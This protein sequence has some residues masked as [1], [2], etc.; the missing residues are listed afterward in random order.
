MS[1]DTSIGAVLVWFRLDLRIRDNP[2]LYHAAA[3]GLPVIPVF[4]WAPE[5]EGRWAPGAA[6]KW[7][8]HQSLAALNADLEKAGSRLIVRQGETATVLRNL[9]RDTGASAV[10]WNRRY[11]PAVFQRDAKLESA[12][13]G[14]GLSIKTFNSA[15]LFEPWDMATKQGGPFRVFTPFWRACLARGKMADARPGPQNWRNPQA[16]PESTPLSALGLEPVIQWTGGMRAAWNPGEQGAWDRLVEFSR[17]TVENYQLQRDIPGI[18][19]TS[20]LSPHLHFGEIGPRQ[21]WN[22]LE[23]SMLENLGSGSQGAESFLRQVVWREFSYHILHHFPHSADRPLREDFARFPWGHAPKALRAWQKGQTGYPIIDAGMRE[24]WSTGWMH[25]RV[26][27]VVASFLVK[28]LL[29]SWTAGAE[30]FC[31][32]L[33]DADLACNS[34]G[35]QWTAGCGVDPAPY[36][37][38]FNPVSQGER[39]DAS[40]EYVRRWV[41]EVAALPDKLIHSPWQVAPILLQEA[42]IVLGKTYPYP[43]VDLAETRARALQA[44][45]NRNV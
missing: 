13:K 35:W 38:I 9:I 41:P 6:S 32:T 5:E 10:Y 21:V 42:G 31:D 44:Y 25:N 40:G 27:L 28:N 29:V 39:F 3:T 12:L 17:D 24:L 15:L 22:H 36:F 4:V 45:A 37:R 33:V 19:G 34:M 23:K 2:A 18:V 1:K 8:L 16:W 26:R 11:E 14:E 30:W 20:R 43:V 7:W